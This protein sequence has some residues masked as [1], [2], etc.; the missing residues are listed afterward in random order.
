MKR[1]N[2]TPFGMLFT[3]TFDGMELHI[4]LLPGT[5]LSQDDVAVCR[6]GSFACKNLFL[7]SCGDPRQL[8]RQEFMVDVELRGIGRIFRCLSV[9]LAFNIDPENEGVSIRRLSIEPYTINELRRRE[10]VIYTPL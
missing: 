10:H 1:T 2:R 4:D 8:R 7:F 9:P 3:D 5:Q 6:C